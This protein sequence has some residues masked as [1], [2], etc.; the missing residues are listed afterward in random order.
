MPRF[1]SCLLCVTFFLNFNLYANTSPD[2]KIIS[3]LLTDLNKNALQI[4]A[5]EQEQL[6]NEL[7]IESNLYILSPTAFMRGGYQNQDT[8][9]T[10]P[11]SPSNSTIKDLE[12]GFEKQWKQGFKT[13]LNYLLEDSATQFPTR[14]NFNFISPTLSLSVSTNIIQ[15]LI[16]DRYGHLLAKN[17]TQNK[18]VDLESKIEKKAVLVQGLL[19]FSMILEIREELSLQEDLCENIQ[20]QTK[21]LEQKRNRGTV[22]KREYLLGLKELTNCQASIES[23]KRRLLENSKNFSST[24]N[25][26]FETYQAVQT[27]QLF[28]EV[29]K[30]Y[31]SFDNLTKEVDINN[32]D[33]ILSLS[34]QV[35][36]MEF[37]QEEFDAQASTNLNLEVRSGLT[38]INSTFSNSHEDI[39]TREH[40]FVFVGFRVDLPL[41]D[42]QAVAQ[43][44][45]N[46]YRLEA[47]KKQKEISLKQKEYRFETLE[48]TLKQD[49]LIYEKYEQTIA[50]SRDIIKEANRDFEN[51][52]IDFNTVTEFNK[53]LIQDQKNFSSHRIQLIVRVVEYLDFFQYFDHYL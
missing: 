22:S 48:T 49:L 15:D 35:K 50:Y 16:Y 7:D 38:G 46:R 30:A 47:L 11:F 3:N 12:V 5:S 33:Q 26:D 8:P 20:T 13:S 1:L 42:R 43:A 14:P 41:K 2:A 31:T 18:V 27:E 24:Y 45:A 37:Q 9:P 51:G 36:S 40:P 21:N 10:S 6:A 19:D 23:L 25:T 53:S 34:T 17:K 4:Q 52:R 32:Q 29:S 28:N 44:G 39:S